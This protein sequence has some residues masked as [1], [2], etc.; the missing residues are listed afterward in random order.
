M[1][2]TMHLKT[3]TVLGNSSNGTQGK[4][5]SRNIDWQ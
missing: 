4:D 1:E 5:T 2:R 3:K